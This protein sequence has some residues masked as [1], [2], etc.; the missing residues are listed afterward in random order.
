[1]EEIVLSEIKDFQNVV[2]TPQTIDPQIEKMIKEMNYGR[3]QQPVHVMDVDRRKLIIVLQRYEKSRFGSYM[4]EMKI[5][6]NNLEKYSNDELE[7]ILDDCRF[8]ISQKHNS[9]MIE[10]AVLKSIEVLETFMNSLYKIDGLSKVLQNNPIF[11]DT[12]SE[13]TLENATMTYISPEKRLAFLVLSNAMAVHS[14]HE[15]FSQ[16]S[17]SSEGKEQLNK[18][19]ESMKILQNEEK[20]N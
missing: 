7:T 13:I 18:L 6:T 2:S 17:Q 12:L 1:M 5:N 20:K 16:L 10:G 19:A 8:S 4:K 9:G 15:F 11:L 14:S 3:K